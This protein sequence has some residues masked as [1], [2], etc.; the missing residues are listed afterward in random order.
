MRS[1]TSFD[2]IDSVQSY[3]Q[4]KFIA[5]PLWTLAKGGAVPWIDKLAY[6]LLRGRRERGCSV[7]KNKREPEPM[8]TKC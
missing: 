6:F 3:P 1:R 5:L 4:Y 7:A 8:E 2:L